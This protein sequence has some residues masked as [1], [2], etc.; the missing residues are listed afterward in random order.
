MANKFEL[1]QDENLIKEEAA[2]YVKS[3]IIVQMGRMYLTTKR[4]VFIKNANPFFGLIRL[5]FKSLR[6]NILF[7]IP[8]K[9]ITH[10]EKSK[11]GL[12]KRVLK[13][14]LQDGQEPKFI[15]SSKY[16][17]WDQ[18]FKSVGK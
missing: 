13:L 15:L 10:Y 8:L 3:K 1:Q 12:N 7:D 9:D 4:L 5:L 14:K 16:K 6:G 11:Y 2:I 17:E 18:T